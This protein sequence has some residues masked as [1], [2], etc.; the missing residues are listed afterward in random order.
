MDVL[1]LN[2]ATQETKTERS[3]KVDEP[4]IRLD[5]LI[6]QKWTVCLKVGGLEPNLTVI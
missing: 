2:W 1:A 4:E 6:S 5:G 3:P